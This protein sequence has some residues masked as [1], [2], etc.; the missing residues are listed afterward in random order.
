MKQIASAYT[1]NKTSG[2]ISLTGVNIDRDQLLLIVNTTRNV[3]YYN[4]ADSATT[5]QAFTQGANTSVTLAT[6]VVSASSAHTNADALTIYY[7]DQISSGAVT[8]N[9]LGESWEEH[10]T[11]KP[12]IEDLFGSGVGLLAVGGQT[13]TDPLLIPPIH[14][15]SK[16]TS[17]LTYIKAGISVN[18]TGF[19]GLSVSIFLR[20]IS[21]YKYESVRYQ[22]DEDEA[23]ITIELVTPAGGGNQKIWK[24]LYLGG[25][26]DWTGYFAYALPQNRGYDTGDP[27]PPTAW[28]LEAGFTG[29]MTVSYEQPSTQPVSGPVTDAQL[30]ASALN[31]N[32]YQPTAFSRVAV[33]LVDAS[34]TGNYGT[35]GSALK[36]ADTLT[37]TP[38]VTTFTSI[39]SAT[40]IASN[41]SRRMLTI[42]NTGSGIL[43]VLFGTGVASTTNFSLQMNSGNFYECDYYN[44]QMNAIFATAGTAYVTSLT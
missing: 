10:L 9:C 35:S 22:G 30:R 40:L 25:F 24:A 37:T 18:K 33:N 12:N 39:T 4:F 21:E 29:T 43:Y 6:S 5:L 1:Y 27:F 17:D 7:D 2:V 19:S 44:G 31:V 13:Y 3:T 28:T 16:A 36:V 42:Q 41:T 20:R 38:A 26:A 14:V 8:A 32:V 15:V 23:Y 11:L 34:G